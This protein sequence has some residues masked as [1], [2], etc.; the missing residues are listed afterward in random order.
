MVV[1]DGLSK[2][3]RGIYKPTPLNS[4]FSA[5]NL[6][7][8]PIENLTTRVHPLINTPMQLVQGKLGEHEI[9]LATYSDAE[10]VKYRPYSTNRFERNRNITDDNFNPVSFAAHK[11]NPYDRTIGN[12]LRFPDKMSG[13][14][15]QLSDIV[16]SVFQPDF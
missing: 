7:N 6:L 1:L 9:G 12:A 8:H 10:N 5:F 3:F 16:P 13:G 2:F 14:D 4:M 15:V 11:L